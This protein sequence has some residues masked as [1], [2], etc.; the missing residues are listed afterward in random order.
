M[1]DGL[2]QV[3]QVVASNESLNCER[4]CLLIDWRFMR[5]TSEYKTGDPL[6][7]KNCGAHINPKT[8]QCDYCGVSYKDSGQAMKDVW[9]FSNPRD[10][11][12]YDTIAETIS[13][14]M[15]RL[16][17]EF[18]EDKAIDLIKEELCRK[19]VKKLEPYIYLEEEFSPIDFRSNVR[20]SVRLLPIDR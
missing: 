20:G 12:F 18:G 10:S 6:I 5:F 13:V 16:R 1:K 19:L 2:C 15:R 3:W 11:A 9:M 17:L 8:M 14:D 4:Q 7:C